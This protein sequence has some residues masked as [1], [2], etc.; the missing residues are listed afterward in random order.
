MQLNIITFETK[1]Q[2]QNQTRLHLCKP[3]H[4]GN[5]TSFDFGYTLLLQSPL[6]YMPYASLRD[7]YGNI[8]LDLCLYND[9][10]PFEFFSF[11]ERTYNDVKARIISHILHLETYTWIP[12]IKKSAQ[13][14][15]RLKL[16][17]FDATL[18]AF[19][20]VR[21]T[22]HHKDIRREDKIR[23]LIRF[24]QVCADDVT[25][26]VRIKLDI[27]QIQSL[28]PVLN[29]YL[30]KDIA[31]ISSELTIYQR[32]LKSGISKEAVAHKM[33]LDGCT[34]TSIET[35]GNNVL[36]TPPLKQGMAGLM[37][38][39]QKGNLKNTLRPL[40][41]QQPICQIA[42]VTGCEPPSLNDI[43]SALRTLKKTA[44]C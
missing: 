5:Y 42:K 19:N 27:V 1:E 40:A 18:V 39:L 21:H 9:N 23:V 7:D 22:I 2:L 20:S 25:K 6:M 3:R 8:S 14:A 16:Y 37:A 12:V 41:A 35:I 28:E 33:K 36:S 32:M 4:M 11:I 26:T 15:Q 44:R 10:D 34:D 31:P 13:H 29:N 30:F 38:S 17:A 43:L 24:K